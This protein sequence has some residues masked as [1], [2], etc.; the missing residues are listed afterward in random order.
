MLARM[1][2]CNR[3]H[4]LL[5]ALIFCAIFLISFIVYPVISSQ[6]DFEYAYNEGWNAYHQIDAFNGALYHYVFT[7][8]T[9]LS[10]FI[11]GYFSKFSD[12]IL[13]GRALST[14]SFIGIVFL[15]A[16]ICK[17]LRTSKQE[18][19]FGNVHRVAGCVSP[20]LRG[21]R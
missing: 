21:H 5:F 6:F 9:P 13:T 8:Y 1:L 11:V 2:D 12:V 3:D 17:K 20:N 4:V 7:N 16:F 19:L 10:F 18:S 14:I 15:V